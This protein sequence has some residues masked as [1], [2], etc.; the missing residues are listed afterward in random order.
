MTYF[1]S[2]SE[3]RDISSRTDLHK[4]SHVPGLPRVLTKMGS[5]EKKLTTFKID[6]RVDIFSTVQISVSLVKLD[7]AKL[8]WSTLFL[9]TWPVKRQ[10]YIRPKSVK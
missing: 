7:R 9:S 8:V 4:N 1:P 5:D 3:L 10:A 2:G 6:Q